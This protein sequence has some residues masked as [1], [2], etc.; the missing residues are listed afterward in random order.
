MTQPSGIK[1]VSYDGVEDTVFEITIKNT[2][3]GESV[4][5]SISMGVF[6]NSAYWVMGFSYIVCNVEKLIKKSR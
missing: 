4:T 5:D 6:K 3:T 2:K 1:A